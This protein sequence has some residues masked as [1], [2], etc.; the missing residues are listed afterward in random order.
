VLQ[1]W[2]SGASGAYITDQVWC[3]VLIGR[4][5][6]SDEALEAELQTINAPLTRS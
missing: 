1:R 4:N 2:W 6:I 5:A 3:S